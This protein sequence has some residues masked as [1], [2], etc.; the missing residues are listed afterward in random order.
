MEFTSEELTRLS[1]VIQ[2]N[3]NKIKIQNK[4]EFIE[5]S[6]IMRLVNQNELIREILK[7]E[8]PVY[9]TEHML[10]RMKQYEIDHP[11]EMHEHKEYLKRLAT[12]LK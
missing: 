10:C 6:E 2:N 1:Q 4:D 7:F 9:E 12:I 5:P 11:K 3:E 8:T